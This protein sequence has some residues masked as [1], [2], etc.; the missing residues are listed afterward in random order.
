[1][2]DVQVLISFGMTRNRV[3]G[4]LEAS[5]TSRETLILARRV[6]LV[7]RAQIVCSI[8]THW[9]LCC[10][11]AGRFSENIAGLAGSL[12]PTGSESNSRRGSWEAWV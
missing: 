10:V 9:K 1:M 8:N 5:Q 7:S 12:V 3:G 2:E 11:G 4:R 6:L